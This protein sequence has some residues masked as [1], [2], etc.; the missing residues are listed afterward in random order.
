MIGLNI[1]NPNEVIGKVVR[2]VCENDVLL[3][4]VVCSVSQPAS[5]KTYINLSSCQLIFE[6]PEE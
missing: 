2:I 6:E 3:E 4:D 1:Q 5:N